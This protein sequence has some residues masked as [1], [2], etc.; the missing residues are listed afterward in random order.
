[1]DNCKDVGGMRTPQSHVE[2][3]QGLD[4][5]DIPTMRRT[6]RRGGTSYQKKAAVGLGTSLCTSLQCLPEPP[7]N[8]AHPESKGQMSLLMRSSCLATLPQ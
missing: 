1:R 4:W 2:Y 5:Q 3:F 7:I 8:W 6:A